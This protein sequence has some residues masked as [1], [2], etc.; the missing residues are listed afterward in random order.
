MTKQ[1]AFATVVATA[2][3]FLG[4]S[5]TAKQSDFEQVDESNS[6]SQLIRSN[7]PHYWSY[8]KQEADLKDLKPFLPFEGIVVGDPHLGNFSAHPLKAKRGAREMRYVDVDFDDAGHAPF[9]LDFVRYV[10]TVKSFS[11]DVKRKELV[12]AYI[13]GLNG[14]EMK[15]PSVVQ[16]L[17]DMDVSEYDQMAQEYV[18]KHTTASGFKFEE[19]KVERL[20]TKVDRGEIAALFPGE[21][22][23]DLGK[24]PKDRGGSA[25]GTRI[26]VLVEGAK[27]RRIMELKQ[28]E[29]PGVA[30]YQSQPNPETWI[31][32]VREA[33]WP[34]IDGSSYDLVKFSGDYYWLREKGVSLIDV[35]YSS[36]KAKA[37]SYV[38]DL[39]L[40]D[41]NLLGLLHGNQF[42]AKGYR[43]AI[44]QDPAAFHDATKALSSAYL[45]A[46]AK[47]LKKSKFG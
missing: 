13:D 33:F 4:T 18:A 44:A 29:K 8:L 12:D 34:G 5:A 3:L 14:K 24:R 42:N 15:A 27:T 22:V 17:L 41:A 47:A 40:Y 31:A 46:A 30:F 32:E 43:K 25:A 38:H 23:I 16:K 2:F 26:W 45:E 11:D 1:K 10:I 28:R 6:L 39:T 20:T 21:K 36:E 37:L 9:V 19:G 7:S 35:P